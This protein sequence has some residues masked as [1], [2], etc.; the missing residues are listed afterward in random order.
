MVLKAKKVTSKSKSK[1][2]ALAEVTKEKTIRLN[3]NIPESIY[4]SL[5]IKAAQ[6]DTNINELVLLWVNEY[7][8]K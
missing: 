1:T 6:E 7:I 4:K 5:K 2:E 3:A 8:S